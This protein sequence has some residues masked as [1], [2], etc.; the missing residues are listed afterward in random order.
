MVA[1]SFQKRFVGL[2]QAGLEPGP[3]LPGMKRHTLRQP[4]RHGHAR[5]GDA[6]QLY[7]AMRTKHCQLIGRA[8]TTHAISIT[9]LVG[10][11]QPFTIQAEAGLASWEAPEMAAPIIH[12]LINDGR[13]LAADEMDEFARTDGFANTTEMR[14]FFDAPSEPGLWR[15]PMVL[16]VWRPMGGAA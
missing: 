11:E 5:L 4:R 1:Y 9:V 14:A 12:R 6:L 10:H 7:T 3:W 2:V 13:P 15:L 8:T 16:I